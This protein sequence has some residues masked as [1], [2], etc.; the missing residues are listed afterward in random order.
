M[1]P[2]RTP[3]PGHSFLVRFHRHEGCQNF[4]R[5]LAQYP[6]PSRKTQRDL[7]VS[8]GVHHLCL[9]YQGRANRRMVFHCRAARSPG[10]Q[11]VKG[12][13]VQERMANDGSLP[14][15]RER[16]RHLARVV[17]LFHGRVRLRR[18]TAS[19]EYKPSSSEVSEISMGWSASFLNLGGGSVSLISMKSTSSGGGAPEQ[20][21]QNQVVI[22]VWVNL[23]SFWRRSGNVP[24]GRGADRVSLS[25]S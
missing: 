8:L 2:A 22:R 14:P 18:V 25:S 15:S 13:Q 16:S 19:E 24:L 12:S 6:R 5:R 21:D 4:R 11:L 10:L 1:L 9:L 7:R 3:S 20:R 23:R 17:V